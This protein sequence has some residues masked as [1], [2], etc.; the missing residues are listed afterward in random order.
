MLIRTSGKTRLR[1]KSN[2]RIHIKEIRVNTRNRIDS[3]QDKDYWRALVKVA[4][5]FRIP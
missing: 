5:K 1:W 4:L 2:I 3:A